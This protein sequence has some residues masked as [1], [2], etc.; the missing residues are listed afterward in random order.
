M[1]FTVKKTIGSNVHNLCHITEDMVEHNITNLSQISTYKFENSLRLLGMK[2]KNCNRPLEQIARRLI[3]ISNFNLSNQNQDMF[4]DEKFLPSVKYEMPCEDNNCKIFSKIFIKRDVFLSCRKKGDQWF[5]TRI[6]EIVK[7][8]Y[9][10][11]IGNAFKIRGNSL[12]HKG[13]FF[14]KPLTSTKLNIY[15]SDGKLNECSDTYDI[16]SIM[17]KMMC[18]ELESKFIFIPLLH[19]LESLNK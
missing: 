14:T 7:M 10:T 11:K 13:A 4:C 18:F 12:V 8:K 16:E 1:N 9:A 2:L 19:S 17:A 6:G 5:L 3:E 15:Q